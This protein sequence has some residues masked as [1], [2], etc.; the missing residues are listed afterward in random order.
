MVPKDKWKIN[1]QKTAFVV[2]DLQNTYVHPGAPLEV[3]GARNFIPRL[4]EAARVCRKLGMPVIHTYHTSNT[5]LSD[6]GIL[7]EIRPRTS[8][9]L[10]A[11][12]GRRGVALYETLEV[13]DTDYVLR[14]IRYS[15][16]IP[17]SST[18]EPLL[19][20]LGR[21]SII[22]GGVLTDVCVA[23]TAQ[24]AMMLGFK[25]FYVADFTATLSEER[26]KITLEVLDRHFVKVISFPELMKELGSLLPY[27]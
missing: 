20:G 16:F 14:K 2:I 18:I 24:D 11:V 23:T 19:R 1:P 4:N 9:E 3:S 26:Q 25:V 22:I 15:A 6:A 7:Q 12:D 27:R 17:G 8:S 10:E 21:D 13:L 5:D